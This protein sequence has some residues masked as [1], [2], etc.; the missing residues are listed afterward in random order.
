MGYVGVAVPSSLYINRVNPAM[1]SAINTTRISGDLSYT[2]V[3]ATGNLGSTYQAFTGFSGAGF[4]VPIWKTVFATGVYPYSRLDYNQRQV[5]RLELPETDTTSLEYRY[6]GIGGLSTVPFALAFTPYNNR[7][8]GTVRMGVSM[9]LMF[10][11]VARTRET[12]FGGAL[13]PQLMSSIEE[14]ASGTTLTFGGSY[15]KPRFFSLTDVLTLGASFT[16]GATLS[17]ERRDFLRGNG[18]ED[19]LQSPTSTVRLPSTLALGISYL[20]DVYLL[21]L[22]VVV[23]NWSAFEYFGEDVAYARNSLRIGVGGEK[24]PS[25]ER[26]A[27]FFQRLAY[28]AGAYY[29][30]TPLR[31]ANRAVDEIGFTAGIGIPISGGLSRFD[32]N[33]EYAMRGTTAQNLIQ[34]NIFRVRFALN[35]GELWFQKRKIE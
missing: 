4:A 18:I 8:R 17:G 3:S 29:H 25:R 2:G 14:R 5:G 11:T 10:G 31:L 9:N 15:T 19:T 26:L 7:F 16:T 1:L 20:N 24:Q 35:A 34:E 28:R 13:T 6:R 30:Q 23:Q 21:G 22:D 33:L 27:T 32:I 12:F